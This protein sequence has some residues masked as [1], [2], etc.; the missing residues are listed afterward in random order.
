MLFTKAGTV[1]YSLRSMRLSAI[2]LAARG[3]PAGLTEKQ[4]HFIQSEQ[5]H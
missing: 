5:T 3:I 1:L 4:S 2:A